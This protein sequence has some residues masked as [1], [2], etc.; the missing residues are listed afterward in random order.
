MNYHIIFSQI[1]KNCVHLTM[2]DKNASNSRNS[3]FKLFGIFDNLIEYG[4][5]FLI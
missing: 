5:F 1:K 4:N 3:Q 2:L